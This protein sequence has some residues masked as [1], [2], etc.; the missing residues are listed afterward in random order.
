M[1]SAI[2]LTKNEEK[3]IKKCLKSLNW[4]DEIIVID[5]F[6]NDKTIKIAKKLGTKVY[7]RHLNNDFAAQRNFG[8]KKAKGEWVLFIDADEIVSP[9]LKNEIK[10]MVNSSDDRLLDLPHYRGFRIKRRDKFLGK[11][12]R[13]GETASMKFIRLAKKN[14]GLWKRPIHEVWQIKGK[15]GDLKNPIIHDRN[16]NVSQFLTRI[17]RYSSLRAGELYQKRVKTNAFL[18]M[19]YPIGKFI[20]NYFIRLGFLDGKP[21]FVIAAMMTIHSFLVRAKLYLLWKN[22]G[23]EEVEIPELKDLYK[24]Y[25]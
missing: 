17:N 13:H 20:Q 9:Q 14:A 24:K 16:M 18:I 25:G 7:Q 23:V 8:L 21:G 12:L 1:I 6:S 15:T 22:K 11:W 19:T 10:N 2:I 3:N 4:C 5:D